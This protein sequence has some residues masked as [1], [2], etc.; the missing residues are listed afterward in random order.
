L[1]D[2]VGVAGSRKVFPASVAGAKGGNEGP[3]AGKVPGLLTPLPHSDIAIALS[4]LPPGPG[5][6]AL[7]LPGTVPVRIPIGPDGPCFLRPGLPLTSG[8]P[9]ASPEPH[10]IPQRPGRRPE[11]SAPYFE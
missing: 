8:D 5:S 3:P 10:F 9:T 11:D 2:P 6:G 1:T 4:G 7:A